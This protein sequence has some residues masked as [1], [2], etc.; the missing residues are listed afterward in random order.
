V[1]PLTTPHGVR[2]LHLG[3][4]KRC[5]DEMTARKKFFW[6]SFAGITSHINKKN[7][8]RRSYLS[9]AAFS[10][11]TQVSELT[12][13]IITWHVAATTQH[14]KWT[15]YTNYAK[16]HS[17]L[18]IK[19]I[20]Y[21]R[22]RDSDWLLAGRPRVRSSNPHGLLWIHCIKTWES[23]RLTAQWAFTAYYWDSVTFFTCRLHLDQREMRWQGLEKS[24]EWGAS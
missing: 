7:I 13:F 24:T 18:W 2:N 9:S 17:V 20:R 11:R 21:F 12:P 16:K 19:M 15:M 8:L 22:S 5:V 14:S 4:Q 1:S 23:R 10:T 6:K 3:P